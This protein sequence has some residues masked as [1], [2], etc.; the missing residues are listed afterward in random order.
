M[1]IAAP[2]SNLWNKSFIAVAFLITLA[3]AAL[4]C[5]TVGVVALWPNTLLYAERAR[6]LLEEGRF[7][8]SSATTLSFLPLYSLLMSLAFSVPS[9]LLGHQ[10]LIGV[11]AAIICSAFF[12]V[13]SMLL[14]GTELNSIQAMLLASV[15]VLS[16]IL[17]PYAPILSAEALF[18]PLLLWFAYFYDR[19]A[20]LHSA[21]L[22]GLMLLTLQIG[23]VIYAAVLLNSLLNKKNRLLRIGVPLLFVAAWQLYS[24]VIL[25]KPFALP[26]FDLNNG[27]ARFNFIKNGLI[28]LF[29]AG[30]P[31]AGLSL[32]LS[33]VGKKNPLWNDG[34]FRFVFF[35]VVGVVLYTAFTTPII[36]DRKLDY[37]TNRALD[38]IGLLPLIVF[39]RLSE[40]TRKVV[41]ANGLLVFLCMLVFGFP[42]ALKTD[43]MSGVGYWAQSLQNANLGII[44]NVIYLIL[45]AIPAAMVW[46]KPR[47]FVWAYLCCA[48][49]ISFASIM[50]DKDIWGKNEDGNF[51]YINSAAFETNSDLRD[52]RAIYADY[53]CLASKNNDIS[54]LYRCS[55]LAKILYF[56]PRSF[57]PIS[58]LNL[59]SVNDDPILFASS[60]HDNT[61]GKIVAYSG[62]GKIQKITK[63]DIVAVQLTPI[64][65]VKSFTHMGR[66]IN[67]PIGNQMERVTLLAPEVTL[68]IEANKEGCVEA[69][70]ILASANDEPKTV[71]F[72]LN[73]VSLRMAAFKPIA[74][75]ILSRDY[76][77]PLRLNAGNNSLTLRYGAITEQPTLLMVD[78][79][80]FKPC[81]R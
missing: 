57:K 15:A 29:Y 2:D 72:I 27:L 1:N 8:L 76:S 35:A 69:H 13:R 19:Q 9:M 64:V 43:F 67:L 70:F 20:T 25:Q 73:D 48:A 33:C 37:L 42:Y 22:L 30:M 47:W 23:W 63:A 31:L 14:K 62:L 12:P 66:Y 10:I 78:R 65:S 16:P 81:R 38:M 4:Y 40:Q 56:L 26:D 11:Q 5:A 46:V 28:Y 77:I 54:H 45:I 44:R 60:E 68:S 32:I 51:N 50:Y 74:R 24:I 21:I 59:A 53:Q 6:H 49:I 58:A 18:I 41:V 17:L 80:S 55:D 34:F 61:F 52:A 7:A 75:D 39:F 79:P 36:V 71:E 3:L